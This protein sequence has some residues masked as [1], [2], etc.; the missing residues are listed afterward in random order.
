MWHKVLFDNSNL[1]CFNIKKKKNEGY[2]SNLPEEV[3]HQ[4][5]NKQAKEEEE[6]RG[7]NGTEAGK[8]V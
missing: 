7:P 5:N 3:H 1:F 4:H 6:E 2:I 8:R